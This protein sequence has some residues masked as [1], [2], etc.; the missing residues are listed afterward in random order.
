MIWNYVDTGR[1]SGRYN[2]QLDENIA[3]KVAAGVSPPVLR[4]Y[5]WQPY[6]I[7][8]GKYQ[9]L[10]EIN[11]EKSRDAGLDVVHRPTGGRAILHAEELT[12]SIIF[13]DEISGNIE[14]TYR[15]ISE[16]LVH[17]LRKMGIP[18]EIA[19]E[20]A[21]FKTLYK[22]PS[23][24]ACFSSSA[25][26]EVQVNGKKLVGSAQRRFAGAVLQHGSILIGPYHRRLTEFLNLNENDK[27][28]M[29]G[30]LRDKTVEIERF[31]RVNLEE[32]KFELKNAFQEKFGIEFREAAEHLTSLVV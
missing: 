30:L 22:Q 32:L 3:Q 28:Q 14:E 29:D 25:K 8:L 9:K 17:G 27:E 1:K 15:R 2:M 23:S 6:C 10:Q 21:D 11:L 12:Y 7:S 5:Q 4:F 20:Q 13:K 16:V 31:R 19:P 18:A 24:A 26:Y